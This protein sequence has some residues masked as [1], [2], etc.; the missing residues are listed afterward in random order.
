MEEAVSA[1][2]S[3]NEPYGEADKGPQSSGD[4]RNPAG[5]RKQI[6][7]ADRGGLRTG[8]GDSASQDAIRNTPDLRVSAAV[9]TES[10]EPV[11]PAVLTYVPADESG[12]GK[13]CRIAA[14]KKQTLSKLNTSVKNLLGLNQKVLETP[15][16]GIATPDVYSKN[17]EN[18]N[19]DDMER[20]ALQ[21]AIELDLNRTA[22]TQHHAYSTACKA[23]KKSQLSHDTTSKLDVYD[24]S[25][26]SFETQGGFDFQ[27]P[28]LAD[29]SNVVCRH[30]ESGNNTHQPSCSSIK[31]QT[32]IIT[33]EACNFYKLF[34]AG[35]HSEIKNK[36]D[37]CLISERL[38]LHKLP[39]EKTNGGLHQE[40]LSL[41][42][43]Q[44]TGNEGRLS[45][46]GLS[47]GTSVA[48]SLEDEVSECSKDGSLAGEEGAEISEERRSLPEVC[49]ASSFSE[50]DD[51]S[52]ELQQVY[53]ILNGFMLEKHKGITAPFMNPVS[54][55]QYEDYDRRVQQPMW[56]RRMEEKF[57]NREYET[58][59]EFV[60][61]FRLMLENCYRFHG[62]DHWL[63]KQAQK[64]EMMLE[65]KLTLL[66]R[67][68]REKTSLAMTSK[69]RYG[70]DEEKG[71]VSSS[72]RRRSVPRSLGAL[73]TGASESLMVQALRLEEQQRAKEERR[74]REQERKEAEEATTKELED[75]ERS[76]LAQAHPQSMETLWELP[77]IGHFLC[78]AQQALNL[79]EI[80]FF[81]L[82]RCLLMPRCSSFLA[83]VMTS[84]LSQPQRRAT[85][86]RRPALTYCSWEAALR[87]KVK[88]WYRLM[89][90]A[91][92]VSACAEQLGL[93][94]QFFR[95]LGK[96][97]PLEERPFHLLPFYQRVWLLK[98][99]CDWVYETQKEVQDAVLG[100]PIHE[101]RESILG[102]DGRENAYI[103]FPHFCGA[104]LRIYCQSPS[105]S[106]EFPMPAIC[107]RRQDQEEATAKSGEARLT[108]N[109]CTVAKENCREQRTD[110]GAEN[111]KED[112]DETGSACI[113][114]PLVKEISL[115]EGCP[116]WD[117]IR[118]KSESS[119]DSQSDKKNNIYNRLSCKEES[120]EDSKI[121]K[122]VHM[123]VEHNLEIKEEMAFSECVPMNYSNTQSSSGGDQKNCEVNLTSPET[124]GSPEFTG[125]QPPLSPGEVHSVNNKVPLL[126]Q[127][128]C[129]SCGSHI[130]L[131]CHQDKHHSR[132]ASPERNGVSPKHSAQDGLVEGK[133][134]RMRT[135]KK[136]KKKKK[137]KELG[138]KEGQ[139][140]LGGVRHNLSKTSRPDHQK[141]IATAK[142]KD[143]RKK[144]K[145]G[146]KSDSRKTT[147]KKR[148]TGPKLPAEPTF[149]LVCT[150]L[151]ELRKLIKKT[152]EEL[153][154]L[155]NARKK[156]DIL[157]EGFWHVQGKWY[158][159]RQAVKEL[160]GTLMRLLNELTPWEPK[161]VKAFHRNRARL[162]K[163]FDDF[164]K[165]PEYANFVRE[166][167]TG[168]EGEGDGGKECTSAES[169]TQTDGAENQDQ[170]LKRELMTAGDTRQ[171][172]TD[173]SVRSRVLKKEFSSQ[174]GQ[175]LPSKNPKRRQ[176]GSTDEEITPRKRNKTGG[177]E[178]Q[179]S[180]R[181][182]PEMRVGESK[183]AIQP[184]T[185]ENSKGSTVPI[186]LKG[187]KPI[188]ALLAKNVGNKVTL[189]SQPSAP[190]SQ[191]SNKAT[192]L[193]QAM[194]PLTSVQSTPKSPVQ[195]VYKMSNN[196]CTP[197]DLLRKGSG[198]VKIAVQP[199]L[200]QK[201]GEKVMQQVV[202]L[203]TNL[204]IQKQLEKDSQKQKNPGVPASKTAC[205]LP[206]PLSNAHP[207]DVS[208]IPVQQVAP[209]NDVSGRGF[210]SSSVSNS[211]H[212]M[213]TPKTEVVAISST[214]TLIG[215]S[216]SKT[217]PVQCLTQSAVPNRA[218]AA[219]APSESPS[220]ASDSKQEL[221]TVCIR[222][223][224][225]IHVTTR[226]GNTGVVKVQTSSDHS[227][228]S[229][230]SSPVFTFTP[231]FQAFLV[232][233]SSASS[234]LTPS[235]STCTVAATSPTAFSLFSGLPFTG[236]SQISSAIS[237]PVSVS[238]AVGT[239]VNVALNQH[240]SASLTVQEATSKSTALTA[241]RPSVAMN[242]ALPTTQQN[243][244]NIAVSTASL[245]K[246]SKVITPTTVVQYANKLPTKRSQPE[247]CL[248]E[249]S[250]LQKVILV[251]PPSG[252]AS[253]APLSNVSS[254]TA[255]STVQTPRLMFITQAS[256]PVRHPT[257]GNSKLP[258]QSSSTDSPAA[259]QPC[260]PTSP[261]VKDVKIGLN[262]GQAIVNA[263]TDTLQNIQV[264]GLLP[265]FATR[266]PEEP[267]NQVKRNNISGLESGMKNIHSSPSVAAVS[268]LLSAQ[269]AVSLSGPS[270][271]A[272]K[273]TGSTYS[274]AS[275]CNDGTHLSYS[276][277]K[278]G[279][280]ASSLLITASKQQDI[281]SASTSLA[282][283]LSSTS[284]GQTGGS[285]PKTALA[286]SMS[287]FIQN[288][289]TVMNA[290]P[291]RT[292]VLASAVNKLR[293]PIPLSTKRLPVS[294]TSFTTSQ[295]QP[296]NVSTPTQ[297]FS[298]PV[299]A[300]RP[301]C[302]PT[303]VNPLNE[304][305]VQQ[306]I[307]I[308]TTTPLAPGTQIVIN[309]TRFIVPS[310]GLGP[311][312][313][314]LLISNPGTSATGPQGGSQVAQ[315]SLSGGSGAVPSGTPSQKPE[316]KVVSTNAHCLNSPYIPQTSTALKVNLS[317]A[318]PSSQVNSLG[319]GI[320][321]SLAA[322]SAVSV[323]PV[324]Q[325]VAAGSTSHHGHSSAAKIST[326]AS[327]TEGKGL[328]VASVQALST[329]VKENIAVTAPQTESLVSSTK[330]AGPTNIVT[331][332]QLTS[333][334]QP[335]G[336]SV[337][338]AQVLPTATVPPIGIVVSRV[339][340]LPVAKVPPIGSTFNRRQIS[341]IAT[342][343]PSN[344]TVIMAP[345][346][347]LRGTGL[348][349]VRM[350]LLLTNSTPMLSTAPLPASSAALLT[351]ASPSKLMVSPE[352]AILNAI[353]SPSSNLLPVS[354]A[355]ATVVVTPSS[356]TG[357]VLPITMAD[358]PQTTAEPDKGR[359]NN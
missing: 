216:V 34:G 291:A 287:S 223:S 57:I 236:L 218:I 209:L 104:D 238:Q 332:V 189:I 196:S 193:P 40:P 58:I 81:E 84:L 72:S 302:Q 356:S 251:T 115:T 148:K 38:N 299:P 286:P 217:G 190:A 49:S 295:N 68:L 163:D 6:D 338:R 108:A 4:K 67:T 21:N 256:A 41:P 250:P 310:H 22:S 105:A 213:K 159:R 289:P 135:K 265:D 340:S 300:P 95:V 235:G 33:V 298:T 268:G 252:I 47:N 257:I 60:S 54:A 30:S 178:E 113:Q 18:G 182:Q 119:E 288:D 215:T 309:N 305:S 313:H 279:H 234:T 37:D 85:L 124:L 198:P 162:K 78:L 186:F 164:K 44:L 214:S 97:T 225:S 195:V 315:K 45:T 166:V 331:K 93:C 123:E 255:A 322:S 86:H 59:T 276:T 355:V 249:Q 231:Q 228:S 62:V 43:A 240:K 168:E 11:I 133:G 171:Q 8:P 10:S 101:C 233:K 293:C 141:A 350:P 132:P 16:R 239:T 354:K 122:M 185:P 149:Q 120:E 273:S 201:T 128:S 26:K 144:R 191:M 275:G 334:V 173:S 42:D 181:P 200:D 296:R 348:E 153:K 31:D 306:K 106:P 28:S 262:I 203:P 3:N 136:K 109:W 199:V 321:K 179:M 219:S 245:A 328:S 270:T 210:S 290:L 282:C 35:G 311:G 263:A 91:E 254:C 99:L 261:Q 160:H 226:G 154:E 20:E 147:A 116:N 349:P 342:V 114:A 14:E 46:D 174:D 274:K 357:R 134:T 112:N 157:P 267:L 142:K 24:N 351:S 66:S 304:T 15:E 77:A 271:D 48:A 50:Q 172:G 12:N 272:S 229:L 312:S 70:L 51:L 25:I 17:K 103:H 161:L 129:A 143:K 156:S 335:V 139:N 330:A 61:D 224:Q 358:N 246:P 140:K 259:S 65:Q 317:Q 221:K 170:V 292:S 242:P 345:A 152:E 126:A 303:A 110:D 145:S 183:L 260:V 121:M 56:L 325:S 36:S 297:I 278:A 208:K 96:S 222:D 94:P 111:V 137:L 359:S 308:N 333:T 117:N 314:V 187:G 2:P 100:Q 151:D 232:S 220:R 118:V 52:Y 194:K 127:N 294:L 1:G 53:R 353:R 207:D 197:L 258:E 5:C 204:L 107:V 281:S 307:V 177:S 301:A 327:L 55:S 346:Q 73:T 23:L 323:V 7:S 98:G 175:K 347:P 248:E 27:Y 32:D 337:S 339:Q 167:W 92:D 192:V 205:T 324:S 318:L 237:I 277:L 280:F 131:H 211:L 71:L 19:T 125:L 316:A 283:A 79:P 146:K 75:W 184:L 336:A 13:G 180:P 102:Y 320:G 253:P 155:E 243:T 352:G 169:I 341:P 188:Q 138:L 165:H 344:N 88:G 39:S 80:V 82:E 326:V 90:Q 69:G 241:S 9:L 206:Y 269:T 230:P 89:G 87:Q 284:V 244:V 212:I 130:N 329:L 150:N 176:S 319:K 264:I 227:T 158:F 247:A 266:L 76:L 63:S 83:K 285:A 202:I 29:K 64:L 74:Q 343:P